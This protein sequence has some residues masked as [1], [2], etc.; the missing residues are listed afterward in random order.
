MWILDI[1]FNTPSNHRVHHWSNSQYIDK[2]ID[3]C[4][5]FGIKYFEHMKKKKKK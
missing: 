5:W 2:I 1:I 4:L 3:E